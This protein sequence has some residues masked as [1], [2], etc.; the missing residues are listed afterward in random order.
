MG[1]AASHMPSK[2]TTVLAICIRARMPSCIRA[3]PDEVTTRSGRPRSTARS[4]ARASFSPTT[5]PMLPP[6]NEKSMMAPTHS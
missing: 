4:Q 6:M 2:A 3:P 1:S 5:A